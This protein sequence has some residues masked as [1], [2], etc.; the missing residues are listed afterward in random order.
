MRAIRF[1]ELGEPE[2]LR[3]EEVPEPEPGPGEALIAVHAA[4]INYADTRRRRGLY[5]EESPLPF[6]LGSEVAGTVARLGEGVTGWQIG[7]RAMATTTSGGYA[8]YVAVNAATLL[9]IPD[10]MSYAEAAAFPVQALTAY[11]LLRTSGRLKPGESVLVHSAA[12]GVGTLAVQLA[13]VMGAGTIYATASS[14]A[15]L[16]LA[17]SL[18]AEVTIDYTREDFA[19]RIRAHAGQH[20][21]RGVDVILEAVGGKV[22]DE[23]LRCLAPFG[24]LVVYGVAS[25]SMPQLAPAQ[26]MRRCQEVIGFYL[27]PVLVRAD[28]LVPSVQDLSGYL[29]SGALRIVVGETWPLEQAAEAHRRMEARQTVGKVVLVVRE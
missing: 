5:L 13:K 28:L 17:R 6:A 25:A 9:P 11:H 1:H 27:P 20:G 4:G 18:G 14:E 29:A 19:E 2:V 21:K 24:R 10:G 22:F 15:K 3:L 8:D 7:D 12:G 26:L 16:E 23:S